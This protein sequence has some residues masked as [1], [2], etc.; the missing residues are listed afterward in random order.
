MSKKNLIKGVYD[1]ETIAFNILGKYVEM[2]A[3]YNRIQMN[4]KNVKKMR[5]LLKKCEKAIKNN[6][7]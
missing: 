1:G 4:L 7:F 5:K 6:S 3:A 2:H